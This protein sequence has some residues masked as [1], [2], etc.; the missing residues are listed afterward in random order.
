MNIQLSEQIT[1]VLNIFVEQAFALLG[2]QLSKII[3]Y[4][5]RARGDN[6]P[7]S[8]IELCC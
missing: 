6:R 4:G 1:V 5:S 2:S 7:D 8:D 3:L